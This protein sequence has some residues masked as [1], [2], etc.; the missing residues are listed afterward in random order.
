MAG[1]IAGISRGNSRMAAPAKGDRL[2][3]G[4]AEA[5]SYA[6]SAFVPPAMAPSS[7]VHAYP[8]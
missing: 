5:I 7:A 4:T 1:L 8:A 2:P 6:S 3:G